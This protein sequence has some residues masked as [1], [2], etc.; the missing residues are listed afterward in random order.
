MRRC[1]TELT[2]SFKSAT[3][4]TF[5]LCIVRSCLACLS[6]H[7][8]DLLWNSA[9]CT[10]MPVEISWSD[11]DLNIHVSFRI[12]SH[13]LGVIVCGGKMAYHD[14]LPQD[15]T[16]EPGQ[17]LEEISTE[18]YMDTY[19]FGTS[20]SGLFGRYVRLRLTRPFHPQRL[21]CFDEDIIFTLRSSFVRL[22][23]RVASV[24][25]WNKID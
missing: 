15:R 6:F 2:I 11:R 18:D 3:V 13:G 19:I 23:R 24:C 25:S 5:I 21:S 9:C 17:R 22:F 8:T 20:I 14:G 16:S 12:T 4:Q 1:N 10:Q 7:S